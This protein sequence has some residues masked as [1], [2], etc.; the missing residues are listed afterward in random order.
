MVGGGTAQATVAPHLG[1]RVTG[2]GGVWGRAPDDA[3][4]ESKQYRGYS[5]EASESD[6]VGHEGEEDR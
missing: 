2:S 6:Q 3:E 4:G 1:Q 5:Q